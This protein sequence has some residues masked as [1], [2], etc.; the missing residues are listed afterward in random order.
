[1][2][3]TYENWVHKYVRV[4]RNDCARCDDGRGSHGVGTSHAGRWLGPYEN[5]S[6]SSRASKSEGD[7]SSN[8]L[9]GARRAGF[10]L[11]VLAAAAPTRLSP[12][13]LPA[14]CDQAD[15]ALS[16]LAELPAALIGL[17]AS[18]RR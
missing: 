18:N 13:R 9:V 7:G 1:M 5:F 11:V 17:G 12:E 10:S 16:T 8:E 2:L 3:W 14:L 6:S 4:N 15:F